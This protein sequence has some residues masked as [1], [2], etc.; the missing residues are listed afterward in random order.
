[1]ARLSTCLIVKDGAATRAWISI[2]GADP[3]VE[4]RAREL[5]RAEPAAALRELAASP[6]M[7]DAG[8]LGV[9]LATSQDWE[10]AAALRRYVSAR[11]L[12]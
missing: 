5:S 8:V 9:V 10:G 7:A 3:A 12:P 6:E 1:M 4:S 11:F 2:V